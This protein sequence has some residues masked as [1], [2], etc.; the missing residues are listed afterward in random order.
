MMSSKV[1]NELLY[2]MFTEQYITATEIAKTTD[3]VPSKT[4]YCFTVAVE[5]LARRLLQNNYQSI[6]N[7]ST[8]RVQILADNK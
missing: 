2:E 7:L 3:H 8:K 1:V 6:L 5:Q 4:F